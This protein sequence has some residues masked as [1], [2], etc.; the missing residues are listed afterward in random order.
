MVLARTFGNYQ[1]LSEMF[2]IRPIWPTHPAGTFV[3]N[4]KVD[5]IFNAVVTGPIQ[6]DYTV[7]DPGPF[8]DVAAFLRQQNAAL[9]RQTS[10]S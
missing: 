5:M 6:P 9:Y 2:P 8:F 7:P 1:K 4:V 10:P 3:G